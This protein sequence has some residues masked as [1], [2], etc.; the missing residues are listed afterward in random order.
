MKASVAGMRRDVPGAPE[1]VCQLIQRFES[2]AQEFG[3]KQK[4]DTDSFVFLTDGLSRRE[5]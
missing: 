5:V 4:S 2:C 3:L 1:S